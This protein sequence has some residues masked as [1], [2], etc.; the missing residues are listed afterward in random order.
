MAGWDKKD[1]LSVFL[2]I[3]LFFLFNYPLVEIF[4]RD[5]LV[6]GIPLLPLY[7][8][9]TWLV[10]VAVLFLLGRRWGRSG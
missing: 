7:L 6:A 1:K 9:G 8:F 10:A 4:N 2:G 5:V 3:L